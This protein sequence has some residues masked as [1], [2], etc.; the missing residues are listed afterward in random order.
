MKHSLCIRG[1]SPCMRKGLRGISLGL[2]LMINPYLGQFVSA[3]QS[4]SNNVLINSR[5]DDL[6]VVQQQKTI[7]ISGKVSDASG[8]LIPGVTVLIK[9][10]TKG[11]ITDMNG[12]YSLSGATEEDVL[13][14]TFIGMITQEH[15][16]GS[17]SSIDVVL[18]NEFVGL[19]E[20]VVVG[21][22]SQSK[23]KVTTAISSVDSEEITRSS[24]TTTAGALTGKMAGVV[25]RAKDS[26]PGRGIGIEIRNMG[27]PLY[28]IDGIPYGGDNSRDWVGRSNVSGSDAFNSLN[29]EDIESITVLKDASAAIYGLRAANGVVLV[30][31]KKGKSGDKVKVNV[32]SYYGWQ[33]LTRF[34]TMANSKQYTRGQLEAIQNE[35]GDPSSLYSKE[36]FQKWQEGTEQGYRGYDYYDII[37]RENVPQYNI[38]ANVSGGTK[39]TTY[40]FSVGGTGQ[41]AMMKDFDYSRNNLQLNLETNITDRLTIGTQTNARQET[42]KDVGLPGGDGYWTTMLSLFSNVPLY[43][44]YA[45][46]NP[47]YINNLP[48]RPD[49]NPALFTRDIAGYKD[50]YTKNFNTNLY[51][52]YK[53]DFG[54]SAKG[55]YS[56]NYSHLDFHGFQYSYDQYTYDDVNDV[57]NKTGGQSARWRHESSVNAV[58]RYYQFM[59]SYDKQWDKHSLAA[60][61]AIEKSDYDKTE[62]SS[63]SAP[64]NNYIPNQTLS[65]LTEYSEGWSYQARGGYIG[66][67]NYNY[68]DKYMVELLGRYDGSY[69]YNADNRWGFFPGLSAGWRISD[70]SFFE[71][72]KGAVSDLKLRAS[73][74]QTGSE[75]GVSAFGY[76]G[77]YNFNNGSAVLDGEYV[78]GIGPR[79]LPVTNLSWEKNTTYNVGIDMAFM[80]SKLRGSIDAFTK[81]I[82]GMPASRYDV[83]LPS[84]VGYSLPNENLNKAAYRGLEG[85]LTYSNHK[86]EFY[87]TVSGNFTYS[88]YRTVETYKP[89]FGNSW[90]EYRWSSE[91]RVGGI[92]WGYQVV[93]QFQSEEEIQNYTIDNDGQGNTTQLPGDLIYKDVNGD[94]VINGYDERPI[95]YPTGW[96]PMLGFGGNIN[97]QWK[98]FDMNMDFAGASMFSWMQ[99]Y[100]ARNPFHAGGNSPAYI[101]N[102][103]WHRADPYDANSEWIA[104][105]YPAIRKGTSGNNGKN[106]DFWLH[107]VTYVRLKNF[108]FGYTIPETLSEKVNISKLR[109]YVSGTNLFTIDNL[110]EYQIDPEIEAAAGV[111]YPQQKTVLLGVNLTF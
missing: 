75:S 58:S 47:E 103:R 88:R 104:G 95:G 84:E 17:Q 86:D 12:N 27:S 72:W 66:R 108:E 79:G 64:T 42:S 14:F 68:K 29:M 20:V 10:T 70:E 78:I 25:T 109:L 100:E 16:I 80:D 24:S 97:L 37:M 40:Y 56:Y 30:T 38:N 36:E 3:E 32:N 61:L 26:R 22:G 101:L 99:N 8:E 82:S 11:T 57:Y 55:T 105:K 65:D 19:D 92:Y 59:L 91:N 52:E 62:Y 46:D 6:N 98:G 67:I 83:L 111:A 5:H 60:T 9:G 81:V 90:D 18:K 89:R 63:G 34:P 44:P 87:Y 49:L 28:V 54:L 74:G 48:N 13:V 39:K 41:E 31:T 96:S 53:F 45:N 33:N 76:L 21:Y 71:G 15:P 110:K 73:V 51:A 106:S 7:T 93:G 85:M 35:G 2:I 94:G 102:D 77:G 43:G 4:A 69:L 50:N 23:R 107:D 1:L